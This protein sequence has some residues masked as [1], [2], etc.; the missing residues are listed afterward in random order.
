[1]CVFVCGWLEL[2][3]LFRPYFFTFPWTDGRDGRGRT[4]RT[5]TDGTDVDGTGW[6]REVVIS[7]PILELRQ[8]QS[9]RNLGS[10]DSAAGEATRRRMVIWQ[11]QNSQNVKIWRRAFCLRITIIK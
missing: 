4:G 1:M 5:W 7:P 3:G 2:I 8:P 10:I 6:N 11:L 9:H